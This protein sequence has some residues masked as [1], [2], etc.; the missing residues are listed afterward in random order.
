MCNSAARDEWSGNGV[1]TTVCKYI[2]N[3]FDAH[4]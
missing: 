2:H 3:Y 1:S 4:L